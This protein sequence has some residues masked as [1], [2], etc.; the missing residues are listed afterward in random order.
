MSGPGKPK[1]WIYSKNTVESLDEC[2]RVQ[3]NVDESQTNFNKCRRVAKQMQTSVESHQTSVNECRRVTRR[4]QTS[5]DKGD[6]CRLMK[7]FYFDSTESDTRFHFLVVAIMQQQATF[8]SYICY[9]YLSQCSH[10][11][12]QQNPFAYSLNVREHELKRCSKGQSRKM[13]APFVWGAGGGI[14]TTLAKP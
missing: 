1:I 6:E 11:L 4:V 3:T 7:Q 14:P 9:Y 8:F 5:V 10:S 12:H 2:I 13:G